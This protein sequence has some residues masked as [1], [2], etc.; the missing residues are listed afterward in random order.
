[1]NMKNEILDRK[2]ACMYMIYCH[3]N[4]HI[5]NHCRLL[6]TVKKWQVKYRSFDVTMFIIT[7]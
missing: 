6:V 1:M 3:T 5:P 4:F 2:F 7:Y